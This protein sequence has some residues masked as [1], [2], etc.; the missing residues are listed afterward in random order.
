[1]AHSPIGKRGRRSPQPKGKKPR[2][3][4]LTSAQQWGEAREKKVKGQ[5]FCAEATIAV[6]KELTGCE[7]PLSRTGRNKH[8]AEKPPLPANPTQ[9]LKALE[10]EIMRLTRLQPER[11]AT[12]EVVWEAMATTIPF[13]EEY[14]ELFVKAREGG[15]K[16]KGEGKGGGP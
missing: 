11:R 8:W 14:V 15:G 3:Q 2:A 4:K 13:S 16:D 10:A 1:M 7:W 5:K 9:E 6:Y 12:V